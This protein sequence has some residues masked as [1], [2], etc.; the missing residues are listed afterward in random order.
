MWNTNYQTDEQSS[1]IETIERK[2]DH[3]WMKSVLN[4]RLPISPSIDL[5]EW[6]F[7]NKKNGIKKFLCVS[8][9]HCFMFNSSSCGSISDCRLPSFPSC[10]QFSI[11][12]C[13]CGLSSRTVLDSECLANRTKIEN[14]SPMKTENIYQF[15]NRIIVIRFRF[16]FGLW[17]TNTEIAFICFVLFLSP[18]LYLSYFGAISKKSCF[19]INGY[20][21]FK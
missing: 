4:Q 14:S 10:F 13:L 12:K 17:V 21:L 5:Y 16:G 7:V 2:P 20:I 1:W 15:R 3:R 11:L 19:D 18:S 9:L 6:K 8:M